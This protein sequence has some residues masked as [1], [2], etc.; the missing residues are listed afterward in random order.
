MQNLPDIKFAVTLSLVL[1]ALTWVGFVHHVALD[2]GVAIAGFL[3]WPVIVLISMGV[4]AAIFMSSRLNV[5]RMI[6]RLAQVMTTRP[7]TFLGSVLLLFLIAALVLRVRASLLGDSYTLIYNFI[8]Y[9]TGN[10][11]LAPWHEPLS[12]YVVY[13]LVHWLGPIEFPQIYASFSIA[14]IILGCCFIVATYFIVKTLFS[15]P[16][17]RLLTFLFLLV[18]PYMEFYLGYI[19]IYAVST[20]LLATYVLCS[21]LVLNGK[22]YFWLLPPLYVLVTF[23]HYINGLLGLSLLYTAYIEYRRKRVS[24]IV[25]GAGAGVALTLGILA[26]ARFDITHLIDISPMSH[27]LSLTSDISAIN[28]YSQAYTIFS[29]FHAIDIGNYALFISPFAVAF[30]LR[31]LITRERGMHPFDPPAFWLVIA[32]L[33]IFIYLWLAKIEQ[34]YASDWDVFAAHFFLL[35]LLFAHLYHKRQNETGIRTFFLILTVTLALTAPWYILNATRE[36]SIKRFESLWDT[37]ILSHL[38]HYTH[39]LRL[40]RY[41]AAENEPL[42][43]IDVWEH[44]SKLFPGDPR[45]YENQVEVLTAYNPD[46]YD[47]RDSVY[48]A[49]VRLDPTNKGLKIRYASFCVT[50]GNA[51]LDKGDTSHAI[52][53]FQKAI[54]LDS[55]QARAMN[56]LGSIFA[57]NNN[58]DE[59]LPL[60]Q[61]AVSIDTTYSDAY[62]NLGM[63]FTD[64]GDKK[65]GEEMMIKSAK[66]GNS[67]AQGYLKSIRKTWQ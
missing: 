7:L 40:S 10:S 13:Y 55:N 8:D 57:Q 43:T 60:F 65:R 39:N 58:E 50:E 49:W 24:G 47:R 51:F 62:Y 44:Y 14:E 29:F 54:A 2:W 66:L 64:K 28:Q 27:F 67:S 63:I 31:W 38:G 12:I 42:K 53:L 21:L 15:E 1:L 6:A 4:L 16:S 23:S 17:Q 11:I 34:G 9:Q 59:A 19:E 25:V 3:P 36:P 18:L 45:G 32:T 46:A 33:P 37:R 26:L 30:I 52:F 56:N 41:Y 22:N 20:L 61:R 35:N 48:T 5:E